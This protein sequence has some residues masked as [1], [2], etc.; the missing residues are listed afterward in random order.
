[1]IEAYIGCL[2]AFFTAYCIVAALN[3]VTSYLDGE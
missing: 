3:W 1:M 2:L